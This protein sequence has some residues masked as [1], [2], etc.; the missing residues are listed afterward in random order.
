MMT[1]Q[2]GPLAGGFIGT[3]HSGCS[4][5]TGTFWVGFGSWPVRIAG[6]AASVYG[7]TVVSL[8][9]QVEPAASA[10][11]STHGTAWTASVCT[12]ACGARARH[13]ADAPALIAALG[14][15][16]EFAAVLVKGS[17]F[18]GMERVVRALVPQETTRAH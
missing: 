11:T 5:V 15:A 13:F 9:Y 1:T 12:T 18:M 8:R 3:T 2:P 17:R 16:P 10:A 6:T 4:A 7:A 14:E